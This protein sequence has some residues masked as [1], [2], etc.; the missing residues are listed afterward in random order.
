MDDARRECAEDEEAVDDALTGD[1]YLSCPTVERA[2]R[3]EK[4]MS[5]ADMGCCVSCSFSL[6][7]CMC[8]VDEDRA[9]G[10]PIPA[11]DEEEAYAT[12]S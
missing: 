7:F 11:E 4:A 2:W 10:A 12:L 1:G 6:S 8:A 5:S 3:T 9:K